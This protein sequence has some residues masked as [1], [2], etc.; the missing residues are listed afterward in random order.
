MRQRCEVLSR[1]WRKREDSY[2]AGE[3]HG[4]LSDDKSMFQMKG[5]SF[6]I[7]TKG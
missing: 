1:G 5:K 6:E 2:A 7:C 3:K 4:R